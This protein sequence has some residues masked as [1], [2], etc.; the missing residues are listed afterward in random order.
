M[1]LLTRCFGGRAGCQLCSTARAKAGRLKLVAF[2][3]STTTLE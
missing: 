3:G 2:V 1:L